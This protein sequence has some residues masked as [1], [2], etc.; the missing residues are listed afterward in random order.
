MS[1]VT[2]DE[3]WL[4]GDAVAIDVATLPWGDGKFRY[5]VLKVDL[6]SHY[7]EL[8]PL[9]DQTAESI[10]REFKRSWIYKGHGVLKV[11]LTDQGPN[12]DGQKVREMC[13]ELGI[14]KRHTTA[15]HPQ[16]DGMAEWGIG[17]VKQTIPYTAYY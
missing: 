16:A 11:L 1:Q 12:V 10:V 9:E 6:F 14:E 15:Y 5:F 13:G 8:A 17:A 4:P 3:G 2:L 7:I